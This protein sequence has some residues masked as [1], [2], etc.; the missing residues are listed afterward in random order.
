MVSWKN[1]IK[2]SP[3]FSM[4]VPRAV[5]AFSFIIEIPSLISKQNFD[6]KVCM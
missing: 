1:G 2:S 6:D 5:E 3:N 4:T